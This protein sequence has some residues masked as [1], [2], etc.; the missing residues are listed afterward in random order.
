MTDSEIMLL[1]IGYYVNNFRRDVYQEDTCNL[2]NVNKERIPYYLHVKFLCT[3]FIYITLHICI[4]IVYII[5]IIFTFVSIF[6]FFH[7]KK[8][9]L[10]EII[11]TEKKKK[12]IQD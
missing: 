5:Y 2:N 3:C 10:I 6:I 8:V 12:S 9:N 1:S 11:L 7:N 4:F